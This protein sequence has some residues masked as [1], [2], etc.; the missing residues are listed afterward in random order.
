MQVALS[1]GLAHESATGIEGLGGGGAGNG[2]VEAVAR[3]ADADSGLLGLVDAFGHYHAGCRGVDDAVRIAVNQE[4]DYGGIRHIAHIGCHGHG[5]LD[6]VVLASL[7]RGGQQTARARDGRALPTA[8]HVL[9]VVRID[10]RFAIGTAQSPFAQF[11]VGGGGKVVALEGQDVVLEE[12]EEVFVVVRG[13]VEGKA[14]GHGHSHL[15]VLL[16]R[17]R[18]VKLG[19]YQAAH[20]L[21]HHV[22]PERL[23][24]GAVAEIVLALHL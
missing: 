23:A 2:N 15:A 3:A 17:G 1:R 14:R 12:H 19:E 20:F 5:H 6:Y 11:G 4:N 22:E 8:G 10:G 16:E 13:D 21:L 18:G 9:L 24:V 7:E